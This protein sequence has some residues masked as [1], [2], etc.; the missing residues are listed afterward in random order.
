[1]G[2]HGGRTEDEMKTTTLTVL[3]VALTL[4][5]CFTGKYRQ[6]GVEV[7]LRETEAIRTDVA[8]ATKAVVEIAQEIETAVAEDRP[9]EV[10][11]AVT[12]AATALQSAHDRANLVGQVLGVMQEDVGRTEKPA[13]KTKA[14]VVAWCAKYR[15]VVQVTRMLSAAV[16]SRVP[17]GGLFKPK[18]KLPAKGW[19]ATSIAALISAAL[20]AVGAGEGARRGVKRVKRKRADH[21]EFEAEAL[22]ALDEIKR[23]HPK[24]VKEATKAD[25]RPHVRAAFVRREATT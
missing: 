8:E 23:K 18:P 10:S 12:E 11:A 1:L 2:L 13:P 19:S 9:P 5:G 17:L 21:A 20:A 7:S 24:A 3:L 14:E 16:A 4:P 15:M 6:Q 25:K 22:A